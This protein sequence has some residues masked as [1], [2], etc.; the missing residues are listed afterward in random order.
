MSVIGVLALC[1]NVGA[2]ALLYRFREGDANVRSAWL[3]SRND[4][5]GNIAVVFAAAGVWA[6]G[7]SWPDLVVALAMSML[8]VHSS[9]RIVRQASDEL[10]Q[11][12]PR[13]SRAATT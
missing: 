5:I 4:A 12:Q 9:I 11:V 6:S 13:R 2:A 7:S 10:R 8:F 3:C 1:V